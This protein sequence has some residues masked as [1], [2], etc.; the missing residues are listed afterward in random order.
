[1]GTAADKRVWCTFLLDRGASQYQDWQQG[2]LEGQI[3]RLEIARYG[4]CSFGAGTGQCWNR[5]RWKLVRCFRW[6]SAV[7]GTAAMRLARRSVDLRIAFGACDRLLNDST[8]PA[9]RQREC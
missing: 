7:H 4:C 8:T 6:Q 5:K 2:E 3:L 1:M 9:L